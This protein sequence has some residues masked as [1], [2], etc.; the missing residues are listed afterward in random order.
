MPPEHAG[1][2][3]TESPAAQEARRYFDQ[4]NRDY[5]RVHQTKEDLFWA[6]H[7]AT[8]DDFS[9]FADAE[10]AYKTFISDPA[11]LEATRGHVEALSD[12]SASTPPDLLHGLR[13]WLAF[14]RAHVIQGATAQAL[15]ADLVEAESALFGKRKALTLY[16]VNDAGEREE[17]TLSMLATNLLANPQEERRRSSHAAFGE[18]ER[19][20]LTNGYL[21]VVALRNRFARA[22]GY[23]DFFDYKVRTNERMSPD[24]LFEILD[25]F[26][27]RTSEANRRGLK[28]LRGEHGDEATSPWNIRFHMSGDV[29]RDMD[30]YVPF[31]KA[32]RRWIESFRRLGITFRGATMQLDLLERKGK[33]QN[34]FCHSPMPAHFDAEGRWVPGR[35]NFTS[36]ATPDQVGSGWRALH[37]LFHEG[38]HAAHFAN[39]V[40]NSPCFSQ[41]YAPTSASYAETQSMFCDRLL[42]DADWL[43]RYARNGQGEAIPPALVRARIESRIP[44]MAFDERS[45]ALVSYFEAAVYRMK[46][47]DRTAD[48]V[49]ELARDTETQILGQPSPRPLL[50][51]PHLLN[52]E[53]SAAY[54]GYLLA[55][56]GVY[57]TRASLL[58]RFGYL[59]DNP[60]VGPLLAEHYWGPGNSVS[61]DAS[62]ESLTG[63]GLSARALADACNQSVDDAWADAEACMQSAAA[64]AYPD[65]A[66]ASLDATIRI[67]HGLEV[68]ADSSESEDAMCS[69]FE[70]WV[71]ERFGP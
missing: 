28:A 4:L 69:T 31:G 50:A 11:R 40:Q 19:W 24:Q 53:S 70:R 18:L 8:S 23:D 58:D 48:A 65:E 43:R 39:V 33:Y 42:E 7:T 34:G 47:E 71:A 6:T 13:G 38:G 29:V 20:V 67:V 59:T 41:E 66:P 26:L 22:L 62:L 49:L 68:P 17:A 51:I 60:A 64:R 10:Q 15:M 63:S 30:P 56:M 21:E 45:I 3:T 2:Q 57:Q 1:Q 5:V 9:G 12:D 52:Q 27:A 54:H 44:F 32:L 61:Y 14:F 37:T 16:H 35:I 55:H 46:D 36:E 25:D